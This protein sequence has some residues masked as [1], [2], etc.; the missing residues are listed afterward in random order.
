MKGTTLPIATGRRDAVVRADAEQHSLGQS[1]VLHLLPGVL[2]LVWFVVTGPLA[3]GLGVPAFLALMVGAGVIVIPFELGY[4]L[5]QGWRRNGTL[6]LEG[7]VR[8]RESI[9]RWQYAVLVPAGVGWMIF[10]FFVVAPPTN[11]YLIE[12]FF[13]W[14]P[15]WFFGFSQ[16][17][18][19]YS[20]AIL[21]TAAFLA[22][23]LNGIVA[24]VVEELYFRG[25][26]FPRLSWMPRWAPVVSGGLFSLYH[27]FTPWEQLPRLL[28]LVPLGYVLQWNKNIYWGMIVHCTFNT[29]CMV[30]LLVSFVSGTA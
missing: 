1:I 22:L 9:P 19:Q 2:L 23:T 3:E 26:L 14:L 4:L 27:L 13:A 18:D 28:V 21:L 17:P 15:D 16:S 20:Q 10:A 29:L 25:Y 11:N 24:P 5:Y 30:M 12:R 7:V 8:Y 6:S